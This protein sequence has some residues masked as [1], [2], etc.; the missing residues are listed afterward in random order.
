MSSSAPRSNRSRA[1]L[2]ARQ[3]SVGV[4]G[5][6]HLASVLAAGLA[7]L[8]HQVIGA[9]HHGRQVDR[10]SSGKP[11]VYEPGLA[12]LLRTQLRSGRLS[13]TTD[14][15]ALRGVASVFVALDTTVTPRGV[16]LANFW[17]TIDR[18]KSHLS[19][20]C[21]LV[22]S[23]Q[24]PVGT[25]RQIAERVSASRRGISVVHQPEFLRL[26]SALR[27]FRR[28]T[29]VIVGSD[30]ARAAARVGNLYRALR[31]PVL[32]MGLE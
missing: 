7:S 6:W 2:S 1:S 26:G 19:R 28:P 21:C 5:T 24:V 27:W 25:C 16:D 30:R 10:L 29:I 20:G 12:A 4:I 15:R 8:G 32:H 14:Y 17:D 22:I 18:V 11:P 23:S 31:R 3:N 13:Y 9:S